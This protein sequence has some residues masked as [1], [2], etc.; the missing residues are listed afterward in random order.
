MSP[1]WYI[2]VYATLILGILRFGTWYVIPS[3]I[4][5]I[6]HYWGS[7]GAILND[8]GKPKYVQLYYLAKSIL[9]VSHGNAVSKLDFSINKKLLEAHGNSMQEET[10]VAIRWGLCSGTYTDYPDP[11]LCRVLFSVCFTFLHGRLLLS[12]F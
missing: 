5:R 1:I 9:S 3:R 10:I 8:D 7:I 11:G 12:V 4:R 6:D 2:P